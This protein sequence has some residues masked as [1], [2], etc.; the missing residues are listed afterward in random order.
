VRPPEVA[1]RVTNVAFAAPGVLPTCNATNATPAELP[2]VPT[3]PIALPLT[4]ATAMPMATPTLMAI[5]TVPTMPMSPM[6]QMPVPVPSTL[7]LQQVS[8]AASPPWVSPQCAPSLPPS[9]PSAP[10]SVECPKHETALEPS[11]ALRL[12]ELRSLGQ[13]RLVLVPT[14]PAA[15]LAAM[16]ML[17]SVLLVHAPQ[18]AYVSCA[19]VALFAVMLVAVQRIGLGDATSG[20][21]ATILSVWVVAQCA[22][23]ALQ[24][25]HDLSGFLELVRV[26]PLVLTA[27]R[28]TFF[29]AGLIHFSVPWPMASRLSLYAVL[30]AT[31]LIGAA[32]ISQ[33]HY[34]DSTTLTLHYLRNFIMP[35]SVSF[36]S[37]TIGA[38]VECHNSK[39]GTGPG[40]RCSSRPKPAK[41]VCNE[42]CA[43]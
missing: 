3:V 16:V 28:T 27:I 19:F 12:R 18:L 23:D 25:A 1:P 20:F 5:P 39:E 37:A 35:F 33:L 13:V 17:A 8:A 42:R 26:D 6:V 21:W 41:C 30:A 38:V 9:P 43:S 11:A 32:A 36:F 40:T 7:S 29:V 2:I 31:A 14:L 15:G 22:M 34:A 10:P 4:H 24:S